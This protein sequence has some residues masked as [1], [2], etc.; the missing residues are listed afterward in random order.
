ML[1]T[2][3]FGAVGTLADVKDEAQLVP[4]AEGGMRLPPGHWG[5]ARL[6]Q[7]LQ[8][9]PILGAPGAPRMLW[10]ERARGPSV[11]GWPVA[12]SSAW[13]ECAGACP[14]RACLARMEC[15][16]VTPACTPW[17]SPGLPVPAAQGHT[18][19]PFGLSRQS[20]STGPLGVLQA[21]P[22]SLTP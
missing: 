15:V 6:R 8:R 14:V 1:C 21:A 19:G 17:P 2:R 11:L 13:D 18:L 22:M 20:G 9:W 12:G 10:W 4:R 5:W 3:V 16:S 7:L